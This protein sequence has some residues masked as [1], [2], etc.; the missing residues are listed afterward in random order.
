MRS[1]LSYCSPWWGCPCPVAGVWTDLVLWSWSVW[2]RIKR[3][4]GLAANPCAMPV[5]HMGA[6]TLG[7]SL[8]LHI[9][10]TLFVLHRCWLFPRYSVSLRHQTPRHSRWLWL[11]WPQP[12][13][14]S[15]QPHKNDQ[16]FLLYECRDRC[17]LHLRPHLFGL[18]HSLPVFRVQGR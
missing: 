13:L 14:I 4:S 5:R 18:W 3:P 7:A 6:W 8:T 2:G 11:P 17:H 1:W 16:W 15:V 10:Q 12:A 9:C